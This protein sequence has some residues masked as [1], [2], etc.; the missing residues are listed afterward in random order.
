MEN[1]REI[2]YRRPPPVDSLSDCHSE[3]GTYQVEK[4][5]C[6]NWGPAQC[7][8]TDSGVLFNQPI[9]VNLIVVIGHPERRGEDAEKPWCCETFSVPYGSFPRVLRHL[10]P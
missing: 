1:R 5:E 8:F 7:H 2:V 6:K 4:C 10:I 3:E 9:R